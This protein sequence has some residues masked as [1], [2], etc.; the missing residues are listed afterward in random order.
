LMS[1]LINLLKSNYEDDEV[2][3]K[4]YNLCNPMQIPYIFRFMTSSRT[5]QI[6]NLAEYSF[7]KINLNINF[8]IPTSHQS[9]VTSSKR[10]FIVGGVNH[11]RKTY[12][13]DIANKT[14]LERQT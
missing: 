11:E 7:S 4:P 3:F 12:E 6:T 9:I 2:R 1:L 14:L 10:I 8:E 5:L 13:F